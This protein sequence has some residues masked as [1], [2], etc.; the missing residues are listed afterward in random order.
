MCK[1][2]V[3]GGRSYHEGMGDCVRNSLDFKEKITN[4][5]EFPQ[6]RMAENF[7]GPDDII[8][9]DEVALTFDRP[10]TRAGNYKGE[11][12]VTLTTTGHERTHF[13]A[14]GLKLPPM[15]I[16]KRMAMA[17][18]KFPKGIAVKLNKKGWTIESI[19]K[20]WLN[21]CCGKRVTETRR[22]LFW[23]AW[24]LI[25]QIL[26]KQPSR[27]QTAFQLWFLGAQQSICSPPTFVR[28]VHLRRHSEFSGRLGWRAARNL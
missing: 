1:N 19:M 3:P 22:C 4:F 13:T 25:Q 8:N 27:Q 28:T 9:M 18:E 6:R 24:G 10:L 23:T 2:P 7:I 12:S 26:W 20:E 21:E 5:S 17:K 14:S 11:S 15:V 16:F